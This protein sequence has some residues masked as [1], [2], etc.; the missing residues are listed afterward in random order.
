MSSWFSRPTPEEKAAEQ[1]ERVASRDSLESAKQSITS[2][3]DKLQNTA[4][5]EDIDYA[6]TIYTNGLDW[7]KAHPRASPDDIKDYMINLKSNP[8]LQSLQQRGIF[9]MYAGM[10][11][12]FLTSRIKDLETT[13]SNLLSTAKELVEPL[14]KEKDKITN[15]L[16]KGRSTLLPN[17]Y[18]DKGDEIKQLFSGPSGKEDPFT[19][20]A[21]IDDKE[22][23]KVQVKK[24]LEMNTV[25]I[26]RLSLTVFYITAYIIAAVILCWGIFLGASYATNLNIYR[27]FAFRLFYAIYGALFF[28]V[29]VPYELIYKKW[30]MG[31]TLQM[32]GYIPLIDGP[33]EQWSWFGQTLLFFLEKKTVIDMEG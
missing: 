15:W 8:L 20:K 5:K 30:W 10:A 17:D 21:I 33:V 24:N 13:K 2:D 12:K 14:L 11:Q 23:E 31:E 9:Y 7:I 1:A 26:S 32:R 18:K 25:N 29:V 28:I 3:L 4:A 16:E 6:K 22:L 19:I 27:S